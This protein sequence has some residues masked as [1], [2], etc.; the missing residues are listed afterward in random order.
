M[1]YLIE[2]KGE[3]MKYMVMEYM[4][5]EYFMFEIDE[6]VDGDFFGL[7]IEGN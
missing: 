2:E 1:V 5:L 4:F 6:E 3:Y 7:D